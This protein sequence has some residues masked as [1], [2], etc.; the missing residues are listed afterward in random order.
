MAGQRLPG[1]RELATRLGISRPGL[2]ALLTRLEAEGLV[3]RHQGSGTYAIDQQQARLHTVALLID[4]ELKLGDDPFFSLLLEQLQVQLQA[5][6]IHCVIERMHKQQRPRSLQDGA[7]T[8]GIAGRAILENL[9]PNDPPVV[10][11]LVHANIPTAAHASVFQL[12]DKEAGAEAARHL[13]N[14]HYREFILVGKHDI[15]AS[16]ERL[17]GAEEV[18]TQAGGHCAFVACALNY[19]AGLRL[20]RT[21]E[22]PSEPVGIIAANDWLA[23]G[24]QAG[25]SSRQPV[26]PV[27]IVSFDG[28]PITEDPLLGIASLT[29]PIEAIATDTIAELRRLRQPVASVGRIVRYPLHW[30]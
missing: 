1:E 10:G 18:A 11:L 2:R 14:Q 3:R 12:T 26:A 22:L 6:E 25:L 24:L 9:R 17:T 15:P 19:M 13:L 5:E 8:L 30:R 23:V 7:I 21:I 29:V 16:H 4:A 28:L 27:H 20:G